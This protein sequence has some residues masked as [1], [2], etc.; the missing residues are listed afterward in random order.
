MS[1]SFSITYV[2]ELEQFLDINIALLKQKITAYASSGQAFDLKKLLQYYVVDVLGELAFS[3]SFG[4]QE[5]DDESLVPP[6][7]EHTLL[8]S[9]TGAWPSMTKTLKAW[10]PLLPYRPLQNL[11]EGRRACASLAAKCVEKRLSDLQDARESG[12]VPSGQRKDILTNLILARNPESGALLSK[13]DLQT[14]A[15]GFV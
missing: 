13:I 2:K 4:I 12:K 14:E 8:A 10:L 1:Y 15:F 9:V 5:A 3:Q 6:V 7:A 11:F